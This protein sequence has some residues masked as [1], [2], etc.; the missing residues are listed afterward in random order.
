MEAGASSRRRAALQRKP[1]A[2]RSALP[3]FRLLSSSAGTSQKP[4]SLWHRPEGLTVGIMELIQQ[5][6]SSSI[7]SGKGY[8]LLK[9]LHFRPPLRVGNGSTVSIN[10]YLTTIGV[11]HPYLILKS[12]VDRLKCPV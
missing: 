8:L 11:F 12:V 10:R 1:F 6:P 3:S 2:M 5:A 7:L 9:L 4:I